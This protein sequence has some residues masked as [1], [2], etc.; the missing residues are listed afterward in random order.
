VEAPERP[1]ALEDGFG[2]PVEGRGLL[3]EGIAVG[4]EQGEMRRGEPF[5]PLPEGRRESH[6]AGTT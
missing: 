2:V 6:I 5:G 3:S 4:W 1:F